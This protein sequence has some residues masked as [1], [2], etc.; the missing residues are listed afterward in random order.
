MAWTPAWAGE[1]TPDAAHGRKLAETH[2]SRCH[3]V[4]REGKSLLAGA[5][6]FRSLERRY[7]LVNLEEALAEGIVTGHAQ[8]P[9]F[10]FSPD[11]IADLLAYLDSLDQ[12][13]NR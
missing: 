2:C 8:M 13:G 12:P 11:E 10:A 1:R 4:D 5:P 7:P 3:A 6:A 9:V